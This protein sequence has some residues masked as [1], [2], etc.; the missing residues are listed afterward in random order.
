MVFI[1]NGIYLTV[2]CVTSDTFNLQMIVSIYIMSWC[3]LYKFH[4]RYLI[5]LRFSSVY[6]FSCTI[7]QN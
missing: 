2:T 3:N 1:A 7:P 6:N 4:N 5:Q